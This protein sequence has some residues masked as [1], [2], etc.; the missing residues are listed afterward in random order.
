MAKCPN[1]DCKRNT[2][3][4]FTDL[5]ESFDLHV[6]SQFTSI[7]SSTRAWMEG[8][9]QTTVRR[10]SSCGQY[11]FICPNCK[12]SNRHAGRIKD[13]RILMCFHCRNE[14]MARNPVHL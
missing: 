13:G 6:I 7:K 10:C 5:F 8:L 14:I 2:F 12:T 1:D 9:S 11:G 4:E 3:D